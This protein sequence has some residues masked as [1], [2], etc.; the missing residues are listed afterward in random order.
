MMKQQ[1]GEALEKLL[2]Q[3]QKGFD[4]W[5]FQELFQGSGICC[6]PGRAATEPCKHLLLAWKV[7]NH[8][9]TSPRNNIVAQVINMMPFSN[10]C[11][12]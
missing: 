11:G 7:K 4:C 8:Q 12:Y 10:V 9:N 3:K 5:D 6:V 1:R 2:R